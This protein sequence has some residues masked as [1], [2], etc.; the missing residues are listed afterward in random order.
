MIFV[1][2]EQEAD[3]ILKAYPEDAL[4]IGEVREGLSEEPSVELEGWT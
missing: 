4:R 3:K 1:L 2:P